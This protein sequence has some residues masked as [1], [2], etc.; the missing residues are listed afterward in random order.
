L[1]W[2]ESKLSLKAVKDPPARAVDAAEKIKEVGWGGKSV[3]AQR[4][5]YSPIREQ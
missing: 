1:K 5:N 2:T 4:K 3:M